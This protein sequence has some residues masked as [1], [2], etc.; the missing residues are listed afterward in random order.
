MAERQQRPLSEVEIQ[1]LD[2]KEEPSTDSVTLNLSNQL[3]TSKSNNEI[4]KLI[5]PSLQELG[6][7]G[8]TS[9][10]SLHLQHAYS[11][12]HSETQKARKERKK[13]FESQQQQRKISTGATND[14]TREGNNDM[15]LTESEKSRK[16]RKKSFNRQR[17]RS[18]SGS[19]TEPKHVYDI[20]L[21][22]C[23]HVYNSLYKNCSNHR[24]QRNGSSHRKERKQSYETRNN[25]REV[26]N[27]G[28]GETQNLRQGP[29]KSSD[30][31]GRR[32]GM[33][34]Y[35]MFTAERRCSTGTKHGSQNVY[36]AM[37]AENEYAYSSLYKENTN[38]E[39]EFKKNLW[40]QR[41]NTLREKIR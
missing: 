16:E 30:T 5:P 12:L 1:S 38:L 7:F 9:L 37:P 26:F 20:L 6:V 21:N 24:K 17:S 25:P 15:V 3:D 28:V 40:I 33:C 18:D 36:E 27:T 2:S 23:E 41:P 34:V 32:T 29:I 19:Q 4:S 22:E 11:S 35:H 14:T 39:N 10:E 13:S 8:P 31:H